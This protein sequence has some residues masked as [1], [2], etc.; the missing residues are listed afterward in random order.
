MR[1]YTLSMRH[2][3]FYTEYA[4]NKCHYYCLMFSNSE[5]IEIFLQWSLLIPVFFSFVIV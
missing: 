4:L 5:V 2:D 3:F 1:Y